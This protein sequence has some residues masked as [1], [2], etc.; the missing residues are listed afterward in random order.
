M[1]LSAALKRY[2]SL[3]S[4]ERRLLPV[5][6][7]LLWAVRRRLPSAGVSAARTRAAR[8][9]FASR[10]SPARLAAI[11]RMA[12]RLVPGRTTCLPRAIVLEALLARSGHA[13]ELRIGVTPLGERAKPASHAWVELEGH[14]LGEDTSRY[15][16]LPVFGAAA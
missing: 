3:P 16:A 5:V 15:T 9:A 8:W 6:A 10:L 11:V 12:S 2:R 14:A 13:A 4:G 1:S 7:L